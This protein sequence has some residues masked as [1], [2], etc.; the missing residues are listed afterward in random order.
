[1]PH[2]AQTSPTE[3]RIHCAFCHRLAEENPCECCGSPRCQR[4]ERQCARC[5]RWCCAGCVAHV[6]AGSPDIEVAMC[7]GCREA[8]RDALEAA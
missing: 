6:P 5:E 3:R 2:P 8:G 7:R 1:M 4:H